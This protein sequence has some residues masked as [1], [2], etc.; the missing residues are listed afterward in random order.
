MPQSKRSEDPP[1]DNHE[2]TAY[3]IYGVV[4]AD[5]DS[6]GD[7]SGVGDPPGKVGV[8]RQG[9][10]AALVSEVHLG[11]PLGT[12]EDLSAHQRLLDAV[13]TEVPVL[14]LRFG[15]VMTDANAVKEELLAPPHDEFVA[16]LK[17]LEGRAQYV[18][19]GRYEEDAILSEVLSEVPEAQELRQQLHGQ[20]EDATRNIRIQLGEIINQ[21]VTAKREHDTAKVVDALGPHAVMTAVRE[22]T[23]EHDAAQVA[24]LVELDR[25]DELEN[26]VEDLVREW[27]GRVNVRLLGPMA[28]Y[29]FV[30]KGDGSR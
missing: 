8:V 24:L 6:D 30:V 11:R 21:A 14:P 4:P 22:P 3:Y 13:V 15:A 9:K 23:H 18:V 7:A 12:P 27:E 29:D 28:A 19:K 16:A 2:D 1:Q 20:P 5:V 10:I 25:A 17:E 26:A